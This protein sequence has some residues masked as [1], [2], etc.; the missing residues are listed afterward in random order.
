MD[1]N[2]GAHRHSVSIDRVCSLL[3]VSRRT[4]YNMLTDGRLLGK[5]LPTGRGRRVYVDSLTAEAQEE[6]MRQTAL[7]SSAGAQPAAR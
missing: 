6:L 5:R 4:V 3:K 2:E 1:V 7:R